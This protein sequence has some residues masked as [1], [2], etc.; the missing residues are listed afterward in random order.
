MA[1]T[2]TYKTW[3][4]TVRN[5]H[6]K[7]THPETKRT[8]TFKTRAVKTLDTVVARKID[9][10][11]QN[12]DMTKSAKEETVKK[13]KKDVYDIV[14]ERMI[15]LME[16]QNILPWRPS[17]LKKQLTTVSKESTFPNLIQKLQK[18]QHCSKSKWLEIATLFCLLN[19]HQENFQN[20]HHQDKTKNF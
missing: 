14:S 10:Y 7:C 15:N 9:E 11:E 3:K 19:C 2:K 18:K 6:V 5:G 17:K 8:F 20:N 12:H 16:T 4:Y 13:N 1:N